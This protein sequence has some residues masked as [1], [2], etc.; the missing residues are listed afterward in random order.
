[1]GKF[2]TRLPFIRIN[3][4]YVRVVIIVGKISVIGGR[5]NGSRFHPRILLL[6]DGNLTPSECVIGN[7]HL[8]DLNTK[9]EVEETEVFICGIK[10]FMFKHSNLDAAVL[11]RCLNLVDLS[12][13]YK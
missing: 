1:M 5:N 12:E 13:R 10:C 11:N 8:E 4:S 6:S 9:K 7:K 2:V 3:L